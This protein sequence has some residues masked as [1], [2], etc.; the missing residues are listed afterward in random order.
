MLSFLWKSCIWN[1]SMYDHSVS[2]CSSVHKCGGFT[3]AKQQH[4]CVFYVLLFTWHCVKIT[5][6]N[7]RYLKFRKGQQLALS[8]SAQNTSWSASLPI[9]ATP[10]RFGPVFFVLFFTL[11]CSL[12]FFGGGWNVLAAPERVQKFSWTPII[13]TCALKWQIDIAWEGPE[14]LPQV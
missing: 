7:C 5:S 8:H 14:F 9:I 3:T 2:V 1:F 4:T 6:N 13:S 11:F 12:L 10:I